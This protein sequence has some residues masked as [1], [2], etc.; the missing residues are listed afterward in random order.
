VISTEG[1]CSFESDRSKCGQKGQRQKALEVLARM[2]VRAYLGEIDRGEAGPTAYQESET[3]VKDFNK[4]CY[5]GYKAP[6][7]VENKV[8]NREG[9]N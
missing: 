2:I 1:P 9:E 4:R 8:W 5:R 7:A 6:P 3:G